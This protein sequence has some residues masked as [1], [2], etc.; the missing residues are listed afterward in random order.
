[1][2]AT[3]AVKIK[4]KLGKIKSIKRLKF[5]TRESIKNQVQINRENEERIEFK[6]GMLIS[7][8]MSGPDG[9][10]EESVRKPTNAFSKSP[11]TV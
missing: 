8:N 6:L 7:S 1:M 4:F 2:Q 9:I 3:Q 5:P 10:N 11:A